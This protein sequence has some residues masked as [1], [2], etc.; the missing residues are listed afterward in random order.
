MQIRLAT[1]ADL[2]MLQ[3]IYE[4]RVALLAQSDRRVR[5][6]TV[7]W[8]GR[9][10]GCVWVGQAGGEVAGY[11]SV[12]WPDAVWTIDHMSLDAHAYH[13]GL[14]RALAAAVRDAAR[15]QGATEILVNVPSYD[16][17]EQA[18]WRSIGA[19]NA[20]RRGSPGYQW[21]QFSL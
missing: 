8:L 10:D 19:R 7:Q 18:F 4:E 9:A 2:A 14:A 3:R 16:P 5:P 1:D 20:G 21:M 12:W 11:V 13:P 15:A 6:A 17:V